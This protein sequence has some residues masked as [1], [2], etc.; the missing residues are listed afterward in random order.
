[1]DAVSVDIGIHVA[2]LGRVHPR[3]MDLDDVLTGARPPTPHPGA[4][5]Q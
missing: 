1:V 2:A 5:E 3:P 4:I